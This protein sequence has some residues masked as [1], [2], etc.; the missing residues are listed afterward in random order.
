MNIFSAFEP[1][2]QTI[3]KHRIELHRKETRILQINAGFLCNQTC[4]HCHLQAGP[5]RTE[6]MTSG[7]WDAVIA[8]AK[9]CSFE[10]IDI[11]GGA[12]EMNPHIGRAIEKLAPL[13]PKIILRSNLTAINEKGGN[14]LIK[15]LE[16]HKVAVAASF[17]SINENQTDAQRGNL[18]F[19]KSLDTLRQLNHIGYGHSGTGLEISLVS[20]P[21]GAFMP[22]AQ[23]QTEKRFRDVLKNRYAIVFNNLL[24]FA[25]VPI[26]N[27]RQWLLSSGNYDDYMQKL[28]CG[29]NPKAAEDVMCRSL[30]SV[31]WDGFLYDCDFNQA[32]NLYMAG[33]KVH[34]SEMAHEPEEGQSIA[35]ADH[36]YACTAGTGFT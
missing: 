27:F 28:V 17:P 32:E 15:L 8:Y 10:T 5:H 13:A 36:C 9:R 11:T 2:Q 14:D 6:I 22:Q 30:V 3:F 19:Q 31:S 18:V 16:V 24:S 1:F 34:I 29:F 23:P 4:R 35:V 25:N 7:T 21:S 12:P 33:K 20:N 26:G